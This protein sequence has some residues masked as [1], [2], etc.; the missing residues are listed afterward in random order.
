MK[1]YVIK[2]SEDILEILYRV[3]ILK[4]EKT[5]ITIEKKIIVSKDGNEEEKIMTIELH[6]NTVGRVVKL[7][8]KYA[9]SFIKNAYEKKTLTPE[10][11][12]KCFGKKRKG[13][14]LVPDQLAIAECC[15]KYLNCNLTAREYAKKLCK[16]KGVPFHLIIQ[17]DPNSISVDEYPDRR[18]IILEIQ[19]IRRRKAVPK[20]YSEVFD[21]YT[22]TDR[23]KA[24]PISYS[25]FKK[26]LQENE[27][28]FW[29][30][31]KWLPNLGACIDANE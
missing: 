11:L 3:R 12:D 22:E 7:Y 6:R 28:L 4:Q 29:T 15:E 20:N 13:K 30:E 21:R 5:H 31:K 19:G 16:E 27:S 10:Q 1:D 25:T 18:G 2:T 23:Y 9:D 14:I 24:N 8:Q 17:Y 26:Y